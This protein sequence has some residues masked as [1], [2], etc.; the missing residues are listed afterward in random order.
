MVHGK[1]GND[2]M[3]PRWWYTCCC[4]WL[5]ET[6]RGGSSLEVSEA[7]GGSRTD[8]VEQASPF[9][10][11]NLALGQHVEAGG[12][13][14]RAVGLLRKVEQPAGLGCLMVTLKPRSIQRLDGDLL[15]QGLA[16]SQSRMLRAI[17]G[18]G[19][20]GSNSQLNVRPGNLPKRIE[21]PHIKSMLHR[22]RSDQQRGI[23]MLA[24]G[25]NE[26]G[27]LVLIGSEKIAVVVFESLQNERSRSCVVGVS[28]DPRF[29]QDIVRIEWSRWLPIKVLKSILNELV[30]RSN[31]GRSIQGQMNFH[32]T[33]R[34]AQVASPNM[35][36]THQGESGRATK[37]VVAPGGFIGSLGNACGDACGLAPCGSS[38]SSQMGPTMGLDKLLQRWE[39]SRVSIDVTDQE[40]RAMSTKSV[41]TG[42]RLDD[43]TGGSG[44]GG[45][46]MRPTMPIDVV[47]VA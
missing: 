43:S 39:V 23:D 18:K 32:S 45:I 25:G 7:I 42:N 4:R 1:K 20:E 13:V 27:V 33:V 24:L 16:S 10:P 3:E 46:A 29:E 12:K 2:I 38:S 21:V 14:L 17:V 31:L 26:V 22:R 19:G 8:V 11:S 15:D 37:D 44:F 34:R 47:P 35:E 36:A 28:F 40:G 5:K 41:V 9:V 30:Q 6:R